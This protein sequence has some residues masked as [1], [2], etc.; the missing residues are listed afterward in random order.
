LGSA[1]EKLESIKKEQHLLKDKLVKGIWNIFSLLKVA[2]K[3]FI[4]LKLLTLRS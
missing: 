4:V 3:D 2:K 1:K